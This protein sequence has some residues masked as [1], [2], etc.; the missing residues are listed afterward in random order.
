VKKT[1]FL[2]EQVSAIIQ[3][4]VP[5]KY[6]N[7]GYPTISYTIVDYMI[8]RALLDLGASVNLLPFSVY[9]QLGLGE[10]KPISVTLQLADHFV[11]KLMGVVEDVL[12]KVDNF[13]Y[14]IDFLILDNDPTLHPCANIPII[15]DR[16]FFTTVN[17][18]INCR[19]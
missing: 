14:P 2:T 5:P 7:P 18:L 6:K 13:Y 17:A 8:E 11:R 10:F 1:A 19:N 16:P 9:L 4:K 3:H 12:V 15:L